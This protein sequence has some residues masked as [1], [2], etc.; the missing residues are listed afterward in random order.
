MSPGKAFV[1]APWYGGLAVLSGGEESPPIQL[2]GYKGSEGGHSLGE[3]AGRCRELRVQVARVAHPLP[4]AIL[5]RQTLC[6]HR[7]AA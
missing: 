5:G 4:V 3:G 1:L 7:G 2:A 6:Q